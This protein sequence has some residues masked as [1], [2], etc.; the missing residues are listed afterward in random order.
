MK[1][2]TCLN[3]TIQKKVLSL[4]VFFVCILII[5]LILSLLPA[6]IDI[7][8]VTASSEYELDGGGF[9]PE[10]VIDNSTSESIIDYWLLP[11]TTPGWI[12]LDLGQEYLISSLSILNT[13]NMQYKDRGTTTFEIILIDDTYN[14]KSVYKGILPAFPQWYKS[15]L[16]E[17]NNKARF[18]QINVLEY[19]GNGG[20]LNEIKVKGIVADKYIIINRI[21]ISAIISILLTY[22]LY[23]LKFNKINNNEYKKN[24]IGIILIGGLIGIA[25]F[26]Y[27]IG[28]RVLNPTY[29]DWLI[30]RGDPATH[31]LGWNFFR[32]ESW[33][34]PIGII[35]N[36]GAPIGTS[37]SYTDSIPLFAII[38]KVFNKLLPSNFQYF[39][40]WILLCYILQGIFGSLLLIRVTNNRIINIF[41]TAFFVIS[42]IM[43]WRAYGHY[44]LMA[45]WVLLASIWLIFK[46]NYLNNFLRNWIILIGIAL[47]IHPYFC[48]MVLCLGLSQIIYLL[49]LEKSITIKKALF[50]VASII[51]TIL[52]I[53][54]F[55]GLFS[56]GSN[57]A[58]GGFGYYSMNLSSLIN[59]QGWSSI[60]KD[61]P[62]T[63]D[64]QYEGFNY[65]GI[66]IILLIIWDIY[67]LLFKLKKITN[68]KFLITIS[69][70]CFL[71]LL[72]STSN[73]IT[74]DNKTLLYIPL[75][76]LLNGFASIFRASGRLFWMV[77]YIIVFYSIW[78]FISLN[79]EKKAIALI[80]IALI[81]QFA[82]LNNKFYEFQNDYYRVVR[83][84][85]PLKSEIW[86]L[87]CTRYKK[88]LFA[89]PQMNS[90]YVPFS[91]LASNNN[92]S[93]N[94]GYFA[95]SNSESIN[96]YSIA[97]MDDLTQGR[98]EE[99][100]IYVINDNE[101]LNN[102]KPF[103]KE[104][105]SLIVIDG[106]NILVPQGK[107]NYTL[108]N[109]GLSS[110]SYNLGTVIRYGTE[111]MVQMYQG[112]GWSNPEESF[113]WTEG[114]ESSISI[115]IE[116][117]NFNVFLKVKLLPFIVPGKLNVQIVDIYANG[118]K[119]GQW[120]L[121]IQEWQ[122]KSVLIP[123]EIVK[124]KNVLDIIFKLPNANSP[125][126][127]GVSDDNRDLGIAVKEFVLEKSNE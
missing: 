15:I 32:H 5:L 11:N 127:M 98:F 92:M 36:Y 29:I 2:K 25:F 66:G 121:S 84:D 27:T 52:I 85:N 60:I 56:V 37:I 100:S 119:I 81:L 55:L 57:V 54:L 31:F 123:Q 13:G 76:K 43:L 6:E 109:S 97:F 86:D 77:Y 10:K 116:R 28:I 114:N 59:P 118:K 65:L 26:I 95:R 79:R 58:T 69:I 73:I 87:I 89:P 111:S 122:E 106:F 62:L 125:L 68:K 110:M 41:G 82:D 14:E 21:I 64:G 115:P 8:N 7:K 40:I 20:G 96:N 39:G 50:S 70:V 34:F 23:S 113:V 78:I 120:E 91:Y 22:I 51:F 103:L 30:I 45:H 74:F 105:D 88:I 93:I 53:S 42:P 99:D 80:F 9:S 16:K 126:N 63:F 107:K 94:T 33:S 102:I 124:G 1:L 18:I 117:F 19:F 4:I 104:S 17:K 47:L 90:N 108:I 44:A 38:F 49:L 112:T 46:K 35:K 83:W 12:R 67:I 72:F 71:F 61:R 75:N 24:C 48:V 3:I 101:L